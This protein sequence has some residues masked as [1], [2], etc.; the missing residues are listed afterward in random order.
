MGIGAAGG[1]GLR[2][3]GGRRRAVAQH[4][5]SATPA[6]PPLASSGHRRVHRLGHALRPK[7]RQGAPAGRARGTQAEAAYHGHTPDVAEG[8]P[9]PPRHV[10]VD[11]VEPQPLHQLHRPT[12]EP[13]TQIFQDPAVLLSSLVVALS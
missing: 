13:R 8:Q 11:A 3:E 5:S 10:E 6:G 12:D 2:K 7:V 9:S 1:G 4:R